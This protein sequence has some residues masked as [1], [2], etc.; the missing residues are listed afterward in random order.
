MRHSAQQPSGEVEDVVRTARELESLGLFLPCGERRGAIVALAAGR[1]R[2]Q[3]DDDLTHHVNGCLSCATALDTLARRLPES[4]PP[5]P[6]PAPFA[7]DVIEGREL[8]R[9]VVPGT[10]GGSRCRRPRLPRRPQLRMPALLSSLRAGVGGL[11][12]LRPLTR[13][14]SHAGPLLGGGLALLAILV[15]AGLVASALSGS[16]GTPHHGAAAQARASVHGAPPAHGQ[17]SPSTHAGTRRRTPTAGA[18]SRR[19]REAAQTRERMAVAQRTPAAHAHTPVRA[20][21]P[22]AAAPQATAPHGS[23]PAPIPMHLSPPPSASATSGRWAGD[24]TP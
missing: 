1:P 20:P 14:F 9:N 7:L 19:A 21:T 16:H 6:T 12:A 18:G 15:V 17:T 11:R 23:A 4:A 22:A 8:V 2:E 24:F 13:D 10:R 5:A 3:H